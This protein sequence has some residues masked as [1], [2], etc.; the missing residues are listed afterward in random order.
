MEATNNNSNF[1][2]RVQRVLTF[3]FL[4]IVELAMG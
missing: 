2:L 1:D 3:I 4:N